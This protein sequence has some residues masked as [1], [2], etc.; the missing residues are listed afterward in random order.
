MNAP[1]PLRRDGRYVR[2]WIIGW[3][4]GVVRW[5]ELL[6]F[7]IF[8]FEITGSPVLVAVI[9]LVRFIP[10]AALSLLIGAAADQLRP[11]R[12]L[13]ASIAAVGAV[14]AAMVW[15]E[16]SGSL[17][18]WHLLLATL[19]SGV[20]WA[21][22]MPLRRKMIGEIAGPERLARAMSLDYATSTGTRMIGPLIGGV[23]YQAIGMGGVFVVAAV[24]YAV[25]LVL[26]L[27]IGP[28]GGKRGGRFRP[29]QVLAGSWRTFRRALRDNDARC[30]MAV[31]VIFNIWGFPFVSMIPVI[32]A[33]VLGLSPSMIGYVSSIEGAT[34]LVGVI[35][36][37][38]IAR[39]AYFRRI[40]ICGLMSHLCTVAFI[41]LMPGLI[42]L[43]IGLAV[44]GLAT[45]GFASMQATLMYTVA[46]P[47]MRGRYL[48]L[49]SICIGAGLIGFAN[50]GIMAE[51]FGAQAALWII[52]AEGLIATLAV[53]AH[54]RALH[55]ELG[56]G[57]KS[58]RENRMRIE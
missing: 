13:A 8:A 16:A 32:G 35:A 10:L 52:A 42:P 31:T 11:R 24:F 39:P 22:D 48:G 38:L 18:Y 53:A 46:P 56:F 4:T 49:I 58:P 50:V 9:A 20:F 6:A 15:I 19:A 33:D 36:L 21:S 3:L 40:Y 14:M 47:G 2:I 27:S 7:G 34:G 28:T 54:W 55:A 45:A 43:A 17:A 30:I 12:L 41:G 25:S 5:L 37:G 57:T 44:A 29:G 23:L 51:L 26:A 1:V